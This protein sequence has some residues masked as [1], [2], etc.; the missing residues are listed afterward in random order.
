[1]KCNCGFEFETRPG[2]FNIVITKDRDWVIVCPQCKAIY[3]KIE[4]R[5]L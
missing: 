1:M 2:G 3:R 5:I 4:K